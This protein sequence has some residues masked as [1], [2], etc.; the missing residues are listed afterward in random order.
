MKLDYP[1]EYDIKFIGLSEGEHSYDFH[2]EEGFFEKLDYHEMGTFKLHAHVDLL[3]KA[4][5]FE[6]QMALSGSVEVRCDITDKPYD[7]EVDQEAGIVVKFGEELDDTDDELLILPEGAHTVNIAQYL[8]E[9]AILAIPMKKIH[10]DVESGKIGKKELE[11]LKKYSPDS[12]SGE[13]SDDDIDPRWNKL[14]D[15]LNN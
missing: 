11:R 14:K 2:L 1:K 3:K 7:Q 15:L 5:S 13:K 12:E 10:P 8:Y 9:M 6:L 4:N